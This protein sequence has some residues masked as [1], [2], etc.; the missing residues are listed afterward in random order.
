[1][2]ICVYKKPMPLHLQHTLSR[3]EKAIVKHQEGIYVTIIFHLLLAVLFVTMQLKAVMGDPPGIEVEISYAREEPEKVAEELKTEKQRLEEQVNQM[4]NQTRTQLR[5]A[6]VNEDWVDAT[7]SRTSTGAGN[8]EPGSANSSVL[9]EN[10]ALQKKIEETRKM[11]ERGDE[12]ILPPEVKKQAKKEQYTGPSVM[13]YKLEGRR[14]YSLPVPVYLCETGGVV[15]VSITVG[16][17]GNVVSAGI[18][19]AQSAADEC[20]HEAAKHAA[21]QSRFSVAEQPGNQQGTITYKF[22]AQ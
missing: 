12:P 10:D 1:M 20:L 6:A 2:Y 21:R 14:A 7:G 17:R 4:L 3:L 15:V 11:L 8:D 18:N 13:S 22:V 16:Q 5:N 19:A 9:S